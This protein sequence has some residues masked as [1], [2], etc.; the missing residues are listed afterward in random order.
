MNRRGS[1]PSYLD[2]IEKIRALLPDAV[3][4]STFLTGFPGETEEDFKALLD[5]Q[6]RAQLDWMGC[7]AYSREEDTPAYAMKGRVS[8]KTAAERKAV[9]EER[10]IPITEKRMDRFVGRELEILVEEVLEAPAGSAAAGEDLYLG[11]LYCQAP[12]A[13]GSTVISPGQ[14]L[15]PGTF[16]RGRVFARAGFDLEAGNIIG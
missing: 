4:R 6:D 12:E 13:D 16:V 11:R 9:L 1:A 3:I 7:F 15:V 10:Q 14:T 8:R 2:L 5:F